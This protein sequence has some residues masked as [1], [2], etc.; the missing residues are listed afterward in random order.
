MLVLSVPA[1]GAPV[2]P[3][4]S[5]QTTV[6]RQSVDANI[7]AYSARMIEMSDWRHGRRLEIDGI[8]FSNKRRKAVGGERQEPKQ[9][10]G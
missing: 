4:E 9:R 8:L 2:I 10:F 5:P 7:D 6:L 3:P 1:F